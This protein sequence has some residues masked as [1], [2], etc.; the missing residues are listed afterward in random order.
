MFKCL[1]RLVIP[2]VYSPRHPLDVLE[3]SC[4][5]SNDHEWVNYHRLKRATVNRGDRSLDPGLPSNRS[6]DLECGMSIM[7]VS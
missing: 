5:G 6:G 3:G 2:S 7:P 4:L 1:K